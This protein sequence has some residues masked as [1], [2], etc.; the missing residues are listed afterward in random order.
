[1]LP[2]GG[3]GSFIKYIMGEED[4]SVLKYLQVIRGVTRWGEGGGG[5]NRVYHGS[6]R[7]LC[8]EISSGNQRCY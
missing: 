2:G 3:V 6:R 4:C 5:L 1:M 8:I 7:L